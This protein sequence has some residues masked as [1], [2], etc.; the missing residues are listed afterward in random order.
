MTDWLQ[1]FVLYR[2]L[3]QCS[4]NASLQV[5]L[6]GKVIL[7]GDSRP[8]RE[9]PEGVAS[10]LDRKVP[11]SLAVIRRV[12][13]GAIAARSHRTQDRLSGGFSRQRR[14]TLRITFDVE[15]WNF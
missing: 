8:D 14:Q 4:Q 7:F 2:L 1:S 11:A 5:R 9:D 10:D 15:A 13:I 3:E 6:D 12:Y